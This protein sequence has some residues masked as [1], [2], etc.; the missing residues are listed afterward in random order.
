[1]SASPSRAADS[2]LC[3]S[4][5]SSVNASPPRSAP[6][7]TPCDVP[8][9]VPMISDARDEHGDREHERRS[10][11]PQADEDPDARVGDRLGQ[12]RRGADARR[13]HHAG[14]E[15]RA[16]A[17]RSARSAACPTASP[18][19]AATR[20]TS[21]VGDAAGDDAEVSSSWIAGSSLGMTK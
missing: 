12:R 18:T 11:E 14:D 1:M 3:Q 15:R 8:P 21:I 19:L 16:R 4:G 17:A 2:P 6:C 9:S 7:A 13:V 10:V 20:T 5:R